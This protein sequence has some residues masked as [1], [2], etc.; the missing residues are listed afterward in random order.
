MKRANALAQLLEALAGTEVHHR[1]SLSDSP[2][3]RV[4]ELTGR[5]QGVAFVEPGQPLRVTCE[6]R[7]GR[8]AQVH[9]AVDAGPGGVDRAAR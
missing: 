7:V 2:A 9:V 1:S 3:L 5:A 8:G 4:A 6:R